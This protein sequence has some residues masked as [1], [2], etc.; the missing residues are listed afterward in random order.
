MTL[1]SIKIPV[2]YIIDNIENI[3]RIGSIL[4]LNV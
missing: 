1:G 4:N 2:M 3:K